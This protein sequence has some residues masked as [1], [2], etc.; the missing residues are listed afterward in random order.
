MAAP[1]KDREEEEEEEEVYVEDGIPSIDLLLFKTNSVSAATLA[2]IS[3]SDS[4]SSLL[5][6]RRDSNAIPGGQATPIPRF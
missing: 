4:P 6:S 2:P 3:A 1:G 5:R